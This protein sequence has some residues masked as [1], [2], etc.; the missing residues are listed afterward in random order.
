MVEFC[1]EWLGYE[2][3]EY[4]WPFLKDEGHFIANLQARQTGK[5]IFNHPQGTHDDRFWALALA[6]YASEQSKPSSRPIAQMR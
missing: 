6:A 4:M 1:V 2:P 5:I 3:Y